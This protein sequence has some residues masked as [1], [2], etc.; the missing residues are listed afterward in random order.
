MDQ[1]KIGKFL[2]ELRNEKSLTQEQIAGQ[3]N[4]SGR[5][6]SRW[7]TGRNMP[8]IGMLVELADFFD[9]N[10]SEILDGER[11]SEKMYKEEK[12]TLLKVADYSENERNVLM[13]RVLIISI[14]GLA[15]LLL[16]L[17]FDSFRLE[18]ISP[19]LMC[20][21]AICFG[22]A[23]GALITCIFFTTGVLSKIRNN[24][25]SRKI[26]HILRVICPIIIAVCIAACII[27]ND[28]Y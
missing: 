28:S 10:I 18:E 16:A 26:V 15:A 3:L 13:K 5:T 8:D 2:K 17:I 4:V 14:I 22:L 6:V 24:N 25:R 21:E 19:L 1:I 7:E 12:E 23:V 9:V 20:I 27:V 11:K